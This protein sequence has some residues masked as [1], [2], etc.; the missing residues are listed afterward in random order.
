M[1]TLSLPEKN[2]FKSV[3]LVNYFRPEVWTI[4]FITGTLWDEKN[5]E[6][7]LKVFIPT[8]PN[9]TS[10]VLVILKDSQTFNPGWSVEKAM[11]MVVSDGTMEPKKLASSL[12]KERQI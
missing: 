4:G 3:V 2:V 12:Q 7:L 5:N 8:V 11:K 10:G 9:P 1:S 6:K